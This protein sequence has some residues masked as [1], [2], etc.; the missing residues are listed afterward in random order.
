M[1]ESVDGEQRVAGRDLQGERQLL[2]G[3][4]LD[5]SGNRPAGGG[6]LGSS[7]VET[8]GTA[9]LAANTWTYLAVTYDGATLRLYVNG[10]QVSSLAQTGNIATSTNPLQIGGDSIY[11]QYFKGMIDEVRVY[12]VALTA[13]Q[14]QTDMN[15]P[16]APDTQPPTAPGNLTATAVSGTQI[17]LSWT[18]STDNVGVTGYLVERSQG[19][20]STSFSPDRDDDGHDH[21]LQR[22]GPDG[23]HHLQLSGPGHRRGRQPQLLLQ[24]G[25]CDHAAAGHAAADGAG[26]SDSD[27][28]ERDPDQ[29]ELDGLDGQRGRDRLSGGAV[30]GSGQHDF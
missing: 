19:A 27:G 2:P 8:Y 1:G 17:N 16:I 21:D 9:A 7:D 14:I 12:N 4:D 23:G 10:T 25:H 15:T 22:H 24:H 18:A 11:G 5:H 3:G 29:P 20:G 26:Q 13:A 28:G 30:P 6:T